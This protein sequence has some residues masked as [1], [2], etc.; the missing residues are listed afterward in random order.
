MDPYIIV[1]LI[2]SFIVYEIARR[3]VRGRAVWGVWFI[4][5]LLVGTLLARIFGL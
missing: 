2:S 1:L 3:F 4:G 5:T